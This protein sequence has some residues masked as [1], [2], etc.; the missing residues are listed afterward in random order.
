M[1]RTDR[2]ITEANAIYA[3]SDT[4][5]MEQNLQ[6]IC[7]EMDHKVFEFMDYQR[8][9]HVGR[10]DD[11]SLMEQT[12]QPFWQSMRLAKRRLASKGLTMDVQ[13]RK[14]KFGKAV[15][16]ER[17][18]MRR[19]GH[20]M[21]GNK[22]LN[23]CAHRTFYKNGKKLSAFKNKEVCNVA[24][25]K[26]EVIGDRASCPNCGY[27]NTIHSF[28]DGCDACG[29][30]YKVQ[31]FKTKV[32]SFSLEE[33]TGGKIKS[34]IL[35]NT[36]VQAVI[37]ALCLL[38]EGVAL[39]FFSLRM[40]MGVE[41]L[42]MADVVLS[43]QMFMLMIPVAFRS[44]IVLG[45]IYL[46]GASFLVSIYKKQI[47]QE[48]VVKKVLPHFSAGDFYQNL[49]YKLR[50][51]HMTDR[52][53]EVNVFARC[54]LDSVIKDYKDVVECD[55]SRLKFNRIQ[56]D[57]DGYRVSVNAKMRLTEC[58][59]NRISVKY[60]TLRLVLFGLPNVVNRPVAVLR[61]YRC[62]G[63]G[64]GINVL[65]GGRCSYC[66]NVFDYSQFGWVIEDYHSKR[67]AISVFQAVKYAMIG[68]FVIVFGIH[69]LF[70][71][72][73]GKETIFKVRQVYAASMEKMESERP[74]YKK[75]DELYENVKCIKYLDQITG[76]TMEYEADNAKV[77]A[78][79]YKEYLISLGM[80]FHQDLDKG[81]VVYDTMDLRVDEYNDCCLYRITVIYQGKRMLIE[82][83]TVDTPEEDLDDT[84][85]EMKDSLRG[86]EMSY[87]YYY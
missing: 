58:R 70:P 73:I 30:K 48:E 41:T 16:D 55:L 79:Q 71:M 57:S 46:L 64:S 29:T 85:K 6:N 87:F 66:G 54:P 1:R 68:L 7:N 63:C 47:L 76:E 38:L 60:E 21:L 35:H 81:Y 65:E 44:I 43:V 12:T 39:F 22:A 11:E 40:F 56:T 52:A 83:E 31:D 9:Y 28:F 82:A 24:L 72:G 8:A 32:S 20:H 86:D 84:V 45:L 50:N 59:R 42:N 10:A 27:T 78:E 13:I 74:V 18:C 23:V 67:Q 37:V 75:P 62:P 26:T 33:N 3:K 2:E 69:I 25:M 4:C 61:E 53:E 36:L 34:T 77:M 5:N 14:D 17:L 49:E 19:D 80:Q 51:I 15:K